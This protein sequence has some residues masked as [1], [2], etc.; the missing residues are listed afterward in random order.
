M[1][2]DGVRREISAMESLIA[3]AERLIAEKT[4]YRVSDLAVNGN[5]VT[6]LGCSGREVGE[7]LNRLL[8][9]VISCKIENS[10]EALL[11][12]LKDNIT[13]SNS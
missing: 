13:A 2:K 10:R 12:Y 5:D 3:E 6:A 9:L 1:E 11:G 4:P 8:D 7:V